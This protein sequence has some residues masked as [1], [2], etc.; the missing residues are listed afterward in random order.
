ML[1]SRCKLHQCDFFK[2]DVWPLEFLEGPRAGHGSYLPCHEA[3]RHARTLE[4][5]SSRSQGSFALTACAVMVYTLV[6][7]AA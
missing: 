3:P 5:C 4:A 6:Y 1:R 7:G 2:G